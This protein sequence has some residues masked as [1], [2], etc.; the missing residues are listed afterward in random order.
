MTAKNKENILVVDDQ[1]EILNALERQL[2]DDYNVYTVSNGKEGLD[3]LD[4]KNFSVVLAD[5]R[6]P[7]M[8]GVEFLSKSLWCALF[9]CWIGW[10][11]PIQ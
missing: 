7:A 1:I 3:L 2:K 6:M 4:K 11:H 5:Q 8:T 10:S 9:L